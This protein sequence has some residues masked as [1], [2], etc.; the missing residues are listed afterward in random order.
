MADGDGV[1]IL[2]GRILGQQRLDSEFESIEIAG[3]ECRHQNAAD[4]RVIV[5]DFELCRGTPDG[6]IVDDNLA[7]VQ[8]SLGD[9]TKFAELWI[10]KV[11]DSEPDTG[12]HHSQ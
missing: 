6:E 11:L 10:T 9:T 7:L 5:G 4:L 2:E 8:C 1:E 12:S 3:R